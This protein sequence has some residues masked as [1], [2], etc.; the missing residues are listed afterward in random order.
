MKNVT[1]QT[2]WYRSR[3]ATRCLG[4]SSRWGRLLANGSGRFSVCRGPEAELGVVGVG[5]VPKEEEQEDGADE[6]VEDAVPDHLGRVRDNVAAL[7]AR[8]GDRVC[9]EQE[10]E[11][12]GTA[13]V[14]GA[15]D[16]AAGECSTSTVEEEYNPI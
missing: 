3:R 2:L 11:K 6:E 14:R 15:Q 5:E 9:N 12:A 1:V 8:P 10:G 7:G 13:D 16:A 4:S